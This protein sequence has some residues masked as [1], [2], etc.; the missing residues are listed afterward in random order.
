M[1]S[2]KRAKKERREINMNMEEKIFKNF[3]RERNLSPGSIKVYDHALR[4]YKTFNGMTLQEL[5]D[6]ADTEEEKGNRI[7]GKG[8]GLSMPSAARIRRQ[9]LPRR[10]PGGKSHSSRRKRLHRNS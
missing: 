8:C 9:V 6:E 5:L 2:P 3:C 1:L 10:L 7:P 4:K